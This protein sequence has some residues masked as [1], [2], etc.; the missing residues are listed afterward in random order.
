MG[1]LNLT[2]GKSFPDGIVVLNDDISIRIIRCQNEILSSHKMYYLLC[3][4]LIDYRNKCLLMNAGMN[5]PST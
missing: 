3:N 1:N 5:F 4:I 2:V